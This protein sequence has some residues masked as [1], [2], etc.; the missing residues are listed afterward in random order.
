MNPKGKKFVALFL[1][2][3]LLMLSAPLYAKKRIVVLEVT[4]LD[5]QIVTG[6]LIRVKGNAILLMDRAGKNVIISVTDI[7]VIKIVSKSKV[8]EGIAVGSLLGAVASGVAMSISVATTDEDVAAI[9]VVPAAAFVGGL[10]GAIVGLLVG[11]YLSENKTFNVSKMKD[12]KIQKLL[13]RLRTK[14]LIY[15]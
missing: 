15:D 12:K 4:K 7:E 14:A 9:M 5:G 6:H 3:S 11:S 2:F 1:V 8:R 10:L 13:D